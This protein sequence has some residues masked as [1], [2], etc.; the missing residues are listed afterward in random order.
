MPNA[1]ELRPLFAQMPNDFV[2]QSVSLNT[3]RERWVTDDSLMVQDPDRPITPIVLTASE[4]YVHAQSGIGVLRPHSPSRLDPLARDP[5]DP[6]GSAGGL[7]E[8][9]SYKWFHSGDSEVPSYVGT[10][11]APQ[12]DAAV[13]VLFLPA[14][15]HRVYL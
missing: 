13:D 5:A 11:L 12:E 3:S 7:V 4:T 9:G 14:V 8:F 2:A 6:V 15:S 10:D 1:F